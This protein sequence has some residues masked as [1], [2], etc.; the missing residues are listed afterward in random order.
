MSHRANVTWNTVWEIKLFLFTY[1]D[2]GTTVG[3]EG[4]VAYYRLV[5][6]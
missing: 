6:S 1:E 2:T 4:L 5:Q 3:V